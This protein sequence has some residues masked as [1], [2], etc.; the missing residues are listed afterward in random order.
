MEGPPHRTGQHHLPVRPRGLC[1]RSFP[2][3]SSH[4]SNDDTPRSRKLR[5]GFWDTIIQAN[6][7]A[8]P[9]SLA[10][11]RRMPRGTYIVVPVSGPRESP[12]ALPAV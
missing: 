6:F 12:L 4:S 7:N 9:V 1:Q 10:N 8:P 3:F 5:G 11:P 2:G